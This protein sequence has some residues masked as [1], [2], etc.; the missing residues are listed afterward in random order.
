[1]KGY[2]T[3]GARW[4]IRFVIFVVFGVLCVNLCV[5]LMGQID[6]DVFWIDS[7]SDD[8]VYTILYT[9]GV[10]SIQLS[11]VCHDLKDLNKK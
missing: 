8:V 10:I 2:I 3:T 4:G 5:N 11:R 7:T 6:V 9:T 1:M